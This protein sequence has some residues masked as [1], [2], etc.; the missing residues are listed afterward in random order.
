MGGE[1]LEFRSEAHQSTTSKVIWDRFATEEANFMARLITIDETWFRP[2]D[3]QTK[4]QSV[5]WYHSGSPHP[6]K[7]RTQKSTGKI[8]ASVF[9]DKDGVLLI[10]F[11]RKGR[12]INAEY[13]MSLLVE[14]REASKQQ[15]VASVRRLLRTPKCARCR[16]HGVVSCLKGHKRYCRWRDCQCANCLLVV[17]RQR[18]MAAQVALRRH[19]ATEANNNMKNK[20]KNAANV[21]QQRKLLHRNLRNLQQHTLSREILSSYRSRLQCLPS[22]ESIR[23]VLPYMNERMR[24]RRCFADKEL[25]VVMYQREQEAEIVAKSKSNVGAGALSAVGT[26]HLPMVNNNLQNYAGEHQPGPQHQSQIFPALN[27][28]LLEL[29]WQ[30]CGGS[31]ERAIEHLATSIKSSLVVASNSAN[32]MNS[33]GYCPA[34]L[35]QLIQT[36]SVHYPFHTSPFNSDHPIYFDPSLSP[37]SPIL[38]SITSVPSG[39]I[40][41]TSPSLTSKCPEDVLSLSSSTLS[42]SSPSLSSTISPS[43][44]KDKLQFQSA[45]QKVN[46]QLLSLNL[47]T[48][49]N[50]KDPNGLEQRK[51]GKSYSGCVHTSTEI[52]SKLNDGG[53]G[54]NVEHSGTS[55]M[56]PGEN[57]SP[58]CQT[59]LALVTT[60]GK[61]GLSNMR[62]LITTEELLKRRSAFQ[63]LVRPLNRP[64]ASDINDS[65]TE[66]AINS[67]KME[68][69]TERTFTTER[70]KIPLKFSV[71][72]LIGK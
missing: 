13:Y 68:S 10:K 4:E 26:L 1:M 41:S 44:T 45:Q 70:A 51:S 30:G 24:K 3:P 47:Y 65:Y 6:K 59:P 8:V 48:S 67:F 20:G 23:G 42:S 64:K 9:W 34:T 49:T 19:Q 69:Q 55:R 50:Q 12:A 53:P 7:F 57:V 39:R 11:Q 31:L 52:S 2:Y 38:S 58:T 46:Y 60:I 15:S 29:V 62:K 32:F 61:N 36:Y 14:L 56:S 33:A 28:N 35:N 17:E 18:V 25:E 71:A 22:P 16:N 72:A 66:G 63:C 5:E 40:P 37:P 54:K 43:V 21:L 27:P